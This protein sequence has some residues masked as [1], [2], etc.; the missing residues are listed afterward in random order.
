MALHIGQQQGQIE[1]T[2][3]NRRLAQWR[4]T[5]LLKHST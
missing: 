3:G 4:M 5:W 2:L 1:S